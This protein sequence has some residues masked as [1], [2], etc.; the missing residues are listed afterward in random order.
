M[1]TELEVR[2]FRVFSSSLLHF[3]SP[4]IVFEGGNGQGKTTLL[5][6][7]FF[8][9]NLRSFRTWKLNEICTVG[10][11]FF[12]VRG[13][14]EYRKNWKSTLEVNFSETGRNLS[15]DK[16]PL[17]RASD[18][19]GRLRCITFLPEDPAVIS[20]TSLF[21]RRFFDMFVSLLDKEYFLALQ[22]YSGAL[23]SRNFLL[24][25]AGNDPEK[26]GKI[27][28]SYNILLAANGSVIVKKRKEYSLLLA[29]ETAS[30]LSAIRPELADFSI[31]MRFQECTLEKE[32]FLSK[33][34][35]D[36]RRDTARGFTSLGP[37]QD[38]FDFLT[39]GKSLRSYGSRGQL[40]SVSFALKLAQ[41]HILK[42]AGASS[43]GGNTENIV[44]VDDVLGDLDAKAKE[45]FFAETAGEGQIFYTFTKIP[46]ELCENE[47]QVWKIADGKAVEKA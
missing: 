5:E 27:L 40:R 26:A 28:D 13:V 24:K 12:T 32:S 31:A 10:K 25:S 38:E 2:N 17:S 45:A 43:G 39:D 29:K 8:L 9:A 18:F 36:L 7:I 15:V 34:E 41:H 23:R 3:Y 22:N 46:D 6:S 30:K 19:V 37:H 11:P 1:L 42:T 16:V 44:L 21:R 4:K 14:H 35:K 47:L 33:L 20:G